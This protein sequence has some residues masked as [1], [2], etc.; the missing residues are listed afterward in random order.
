MELPTLR[1]ELTQVNGPLRRVQ[2]RS[3][4][5][6]KPA[7]GAVPSERLELYEKLVATNPNIKPKSATVP[8]M[9]LNG[10]RFSYLS[11]GGKRLF[12]CRLESEAF[13]KK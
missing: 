7:A 9:S 8:Y 10:H 12:G 11:K 1:P 3:G 5:I 6:P 4:P 13:F 2:R